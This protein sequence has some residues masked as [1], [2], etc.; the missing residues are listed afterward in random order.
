MLVIIIHVIYLVNKPL[1]V[2]YY[3]EF[4]TQKKESGPKFFRI[5]PKEMSGI[6][7][8]RIPA[9]KNSRKQ[10]IFGKILLD[11]LIVGHI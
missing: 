7:D 4:E 10:P 5:L 2:H 3:W 9:F 6:L 1:Y 11:I 8:P